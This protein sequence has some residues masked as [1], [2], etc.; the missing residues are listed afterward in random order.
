MTDHRQA[1]LRPYLSQMRPFL[2]LLAAGVVLNLIAALST[3]GLISLSGWFLSAS[4][5]AGVSAATAHSF[6]YFLPSAGVRFFAVTRTLGRYGERITTHEGTFKLLSTLRR[7]LFLAIE[8]LSPSELQTHGSSELLTRLTRD[9]DALDGL[10]VRVITPSIVAVLAIMTCGVVMGVFALW[11]GLGAA[12]SLLI[13]G[14]FGPWWALKR[15]AGVSSRWHTLDTTNRT[16]LQERLSGMTELMIYGCWRDEVTALLTRQRDRDT[17]ELELARLWGRSQLLTQV[18][19]GI[20]LT[21]VM[22]GAAY[23]A[24]QNALDPTLI[25]LLGL[26]VLAGFEAIT[27]LPR[28]FQELGKIRRA[29]GRIDAV[30]EGTSTIVFPNI[31]HAPPKGHRL[32]IEHVCVRF[33]RETPALN[34]VSLTLEEHQHL[35]LI[36]PSGSGKTSLINALTRFIELDSGTITL[37]GVSIDALSEPTLRRQMAV[38]SQD[39]HLFTTT[40]RENLRLGAPNAS[41]ETF[42]EVLSALDLGE[43]LASQPDGLD[44]WPDEGGSSLSGG[45]LRRFGVARALIS[46]APILIL[47]EPTEG[48]DRASELRVLDAIYHYAQGRTLI[49]ITHKMTALS[50][51]DRIAVLEHGRLI[52]HGT[53]QAL[54]NTPNSRFRALNQQLKL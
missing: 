54:L 51:M 3:I 9:I 2:P 44:S 26:T 14:T 42:I 23:L 6:N 7:R 8:P 49:L 34:G 22:A 30:I 50:Q 12:L 18:L 43:W 28:A 47:D 10:Y 21:G 19:L 27:S 13:A 1:S 46:S 32:V 41:D 36:G 37:G 38:A 53:P 17:R 4:A 52:E 40:Y 48:L 5:L 16:R 11:I 45:Q 29:A 35:A 33:T 20:T 39:T 15:G 24:H 31:D 25:A